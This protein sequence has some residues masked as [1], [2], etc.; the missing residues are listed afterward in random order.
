MITVFRK[1]ASNPWHAG[2]LCFVLLVSSYRES[3]SEKNAMHYSGK[4]LFK[5]I[6]FGTGEVLNRLP[7]LKSTSKLDEVFEPESKLYYEVRMMQDLVMNHTF[8]LCQL[9][10]T[11][12]KWEPRIN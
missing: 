1:I 12:P 7:S 5:G 4:E 6:F 2:L 8:L 9:Q 3:K 10:T 11:N